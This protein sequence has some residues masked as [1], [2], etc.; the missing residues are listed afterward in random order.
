MTF[1]TIVVVYVFG[2]I[3]VATAQSPTIDICVERGQNIINSPNIMMF[4]RKFKCVAK[5]PKT[6]DLPKVEEVSI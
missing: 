5:T 1:T 4:Y 3:M 6:E 2:G